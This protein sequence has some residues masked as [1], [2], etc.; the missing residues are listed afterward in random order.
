MKS[1][2]FFLAMSATLAASNGWAGS[3][4]LQYATFD[5]LV[6]TPNVAANLKALPMDALGYG[7]YLVQLKSVLTSTDRTW[8]ADNNIVVAGYIP[9]NSFIVRLNAQQM[10]LLSSWTRTRWIGDFHGAYKISKF[11]GAVNFVNPTRVFESSIGIH[12]M[13]AT[14][15]ADG[16]LD[17]VLAFVQSIGLTVESVDQV[18]SYGWFV[19]VKGSMSLAP[20]LARH[21]DVSFIEDAPERNFRNDVCSWVGQSNVNNSR[22]IW[23][24]GIRGEGQI[25]AVID[26]QIRA[27]HQMFA[28]PN[29]N[30]VG[31]THRKLQGIFNPVGQP[32]LHGT[33]V[34]GTMV[35]DLNANNNTPGA[36]SGM[37]YEARLVFTTLNSVTN[38]NLYQLLQQAHNAGARVHS[39]SW[40]SAVNGYT[41][42]C[43]AM[44][45]F[46]YDNEDS[47]VS[48]ATAN[49]INIGSPE[50]AKNILAV[51]NT[52][53]P[54]NQGNVASGAT[55]PTFDGRR[56]PEV[57]M[58]GENVISASS[59]SDTGTASLTG[60]S[61]ATPATSGLTLLA[62]QF[63]AQGR[64]GVAGS[65]PSMN[66]VIPTGALLRAMMVASTVDMSGLPGFPGNHEGFGRVLLANVLWFAGGNRASLFWD[67]RRAQGMTQ[68][69]T[70]TFT[71]TVSSSAVPLRVVM[72]F[73]DPAAAQAAAQAPINNVDMEVQAPNGSV[74]LGNNF[75][76]ATGQSITGGAADA[77]N[78]VEMVQLFNPA[79]GTYTVRV[80]CAALNM[81]TAQGFGLAATG[82]I[83]VASA[84][85]LTLDATTLA[86]FPNTSVTG[87]PNLVKA[88]DANRFKVPSELIPNVAQQAGARTT[89]V[90]DR[91]VSQIINLNLQVKAFAPSSATG[92]LWLY[93][94]TKSQYVH[95]KSFP[96]SASGTTQT[97]AIKPLSNYVDPGTNTVS[98]VIR[99]SIPVRTNRGNPIIPTP[100]DMDVDL[101]K[102]SGAG[103]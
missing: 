76:T 96:M 92:M 89:F 87:D 29:G 68:S 28:D 39:N 50:V 46:S 91:P 79:P 59:S 36:N 101:M 95:V 44:D 15:L 11:L 16:N 81:G 99:T 20:S 48:V 32:D 40:G 73:T 4:R 6:S 60:T 2:C 90:L 65:P 37:A 13:V 57:W 42:D 80:K 56:K 19:G 51:G 27:T 97:F 58:V 53:K 83:D 88:A 45:Q 61:M 77:I 12:R 64:G 33:H 71:F 102:L 85:A 5:P 17:A 10:A 62:R 14:V 63:V 38:T 69:Q 75:N 67:Y 25:G 9:D 18:G 66:G 93:D 72:A 52:R 7:H 98:A 30:P 55:G 26:G 103:N 21:P 47:M 74:F 24:Q 35:G 94:H 54:P 34:C 31:N 100:F 8:L 86:R 1:F 49:E 70:R 3:V 23:A 43:V 41:S 82:G 84:S 78:S 22:P